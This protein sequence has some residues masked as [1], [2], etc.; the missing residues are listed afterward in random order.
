MEHKSFDV[1]Y[2]I[3]FGIA[4]RMLIQTR[5]L[6]RLAEQG[7]R[8][9]IL[10]QDAED[11]NLKRLAEHKNISIFSIAEKQNFWGENYLFKRKYYLEDIEANP[12]LWEKHIYATRFNT[13][14]HPL[15]LIRPFYYMLIHRLIPHFPS[16]KK[17]FQQYEQ[18]HLTSSYFETILQQIN[19]KLLISL[20]PINLLEAKALYAAKQLNITTVLHL[21]SWDNITSK[22]IFPVVADHYILWGDI[23]KEE[24]KAYYQI[25]EKNIHVCGVPHFDRHVDFRDTDAYRSLLESYGLQPEKPYL[26]FAMSA[27][28]FAPR[29]I[30]I[31][32]W[33]AEAIEQ[34]I[35]GDDMQLVVRPHPQVIQGFMSDSSWLE[36][37]QRIQSKRVYVN[38]PKLIDSQLRWSMEQEDMNDLAKIMSGCSIC[39]NSGSTI[40]IE[41]LIYDKPVILTSF[42]ADDQLHYWKSARR[43]IDYTHLKK[44][45]A[46]GGVSVVSN[47]TELEQQIKQDIAHPNALSEQRQHTLNRECYRMDGEATTRS[48]RAIHQILE[49]VN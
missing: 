9:A 11:D 39:L 17:R 22:G 10:T 5:L 46:M 29:E 37:L 25:N 15:R 28:R 33:L 42:D 7:I 47:F 26:F 16:I 35:F 34:N 13:S 43:L 4:A 32:E 14:K 20:Y 27:K 3:S 48:I 38:I 6:L 8:V 2:L 21:L 1:C 36:R 31:V 18:Q 41:A 40:S 23:M 12:A 30:D 49:A 24:L 44:F 19:P 45:V